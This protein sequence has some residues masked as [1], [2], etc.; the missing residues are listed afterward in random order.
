MSGHTIECP[1]GSV[2]RG[3]DEDQVVDA[4]QRHARSV[5]DM[6]LTDEQARAMARPD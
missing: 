3:D 6:E 1:C 2:L 4:A 5:H